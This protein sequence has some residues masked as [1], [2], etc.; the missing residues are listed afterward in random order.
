VLGEF[1]ALHGI[2]C[3]LGVGGGFDIIVAYLEGEGGVNFLTFGIG[4]AL[5][6]LNSRPPPP[7]T[8]RMPGT[9]GGSAH[10]SFRQDC[11][12]RIVHGRLSNLHN[13]IY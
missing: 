5:S 7:S 9:I 13:M 2:I 10:I 11:Y 1:F 3:S 8:A 12:D 4:H 6:T